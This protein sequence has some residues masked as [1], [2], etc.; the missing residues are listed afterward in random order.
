MEKFKKLYKKELKLEDELTS[1]DN[2][3]TKLNRKKKELENRLNHGQER[4]KTDQHFSK[5]KN[6]ETM[7]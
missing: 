3:I 7:G 2:Q 6:I 1:I 5:P 4:E